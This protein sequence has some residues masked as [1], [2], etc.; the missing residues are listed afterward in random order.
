LGELD[1]WLRVGCPFWGAVKRRCVD[2]LG[3]VRVNTLLQNYKVL[4]L[5][6]GGGAGP[7]PTEPSLD[8]KYS[9]VKRRMALLVAVSVFG[10]SCASFSLFKL[11]VEN[12]WMLT[13]LLLLLAYT[14]IYFLISQAIYFVSSDFN[15]RY[16]RYLVGIW[17]PAHYPSVDVFLPTCGEPI[18]VLSNTWSG[19]QQLR[20]TYPGPIRV[21]CLDDA[22]SAEVRHLAL[23]Y[24]F[25]YLSRPNRGWFKKAGNLRYGFERSSGD[26]IAIF[27][28]D[29][30]PR[31]D[32]LL[33][34]LPYFEAEK[35]VGIVQ[36]PQFFDVLPEQN[37]IERGAGAVQ[38]LFYRAVQVSRQ[39]CGGAICVGSNAI[40]RRAALDDIGGTALI[41][42][43][44]DVHTGFNLRGEGWRLKYVPVVLAKGLCPSEMDAFFKQ[45]YRW[46]MGSMSLL[47][48]RKFWTTKLPVMTRLCYLSGF[49]YYIHTAIYAVFMPVVP[50]IMLYAIPE[51]IKLAN[52]LLILPSFVYM[53]V[54][55][56]LWHRAPYGIE[57]AAIRNVYGWAH[58]SALFDLIRKS[59]MEWHPT[60]ASSASKNSRYAM[61]RQNA[62][63]LNFI[64][65]LLWVG[66]A[67]SHMVASSEPLNFLPILLLGLY[68]FFVVL[69]VVT[70]RDQKA[71]AVKTVATPQVGRKMW[72]LR[73]R[74]AAPQ[75][76]APLVLGR[77]SV[78]GDP[79]KVWPQQD[80]PQPAATARQPYLLDA[81]RRAS[82]T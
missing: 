65:A 61:F 12:G 22:G 43:S 46:C 38:E 3:V 72:V 13:P 39:A 48:S 44:E 40:Y 26:F 8:Q 45:Q 81:P 16:H 29:F 33:E 74:N 41:E 49:M 51:Q 47:T 2:G 71:G 37:W 17:R 67:V 34:L 50:L 58:L 28:A 30:R 53:H 73:N 6:A 4:E 77:A 15:L 35:D 5:G 36:S 31:A 82:I 24:G 25:D 56:P 70:Y 75:A 62:V 66:G 80:Q 60:G 78:V 9:F 19:V 52:Y 14:V 20:K 57:A 7:L 79:G 69:K 42:H 18:D 11:S 55:F 10:F 64:P 59:A 32:F 76:P 1:W 54:I 21:I 63:I 23:H 27:D 68:Y